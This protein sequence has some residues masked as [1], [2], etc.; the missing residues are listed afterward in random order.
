MA[1]EFNVPLAKKTIDI[2]PALGSVAEFQAAQ[3]LNP[4]SQLTF[5]AGL[6]F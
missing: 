4:K 6:H 5:S 1:L 2:N 3:D